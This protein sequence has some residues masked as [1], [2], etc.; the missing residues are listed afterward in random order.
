MLPPR[1]SARSAPTPQS[2]AVKMPKPKSMSQ[3]ELDAANHELDP[4]IDA[5][6]VHLPAPGDYWAKDDRALWLR[7][8]ELAFELIYDTEPPDEL[9]GSLPKSDHSGQA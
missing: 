1:H 3:A 6:L 5:L 8:M 7:M 4:L 9:H 2:Q